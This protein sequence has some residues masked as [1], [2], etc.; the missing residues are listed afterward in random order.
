MNKTLTS[1]SITG[2]VFGI[3]STKVGEH[4]MDG[5]PVVQ[6]TLKQDR[7]SC[8]SNIY[9]LSRSAARELYHQLKEEFADWEDQAYEL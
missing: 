2:A 4:W 8:S 9:V 1:D 7:E 6:I 5:R 3:V